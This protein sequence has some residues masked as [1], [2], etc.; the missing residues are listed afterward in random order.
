MERCAASARRALIADLVGT[1]PASL[2][3]TTPTSPAGTEPAALVRAGQILSSPQ[4]VHWDLV[5][6]SPDETLQLVAAQC[7][8]SQAP[9]LLCTG[10]TTTR[11]ARAARN[12]NPE[13]SR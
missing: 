7:T 6:G 12:P 5:A 4:S 10:C 9:A 1:T 11:D 3:S 8:H 13:S 2:A